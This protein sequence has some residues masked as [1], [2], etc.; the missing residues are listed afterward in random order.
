VT[1]LTALEAG[2]G[3][4]T[5]LGLPLVVS[6][7]TAVTS[8]MSGLTALVALTGGLG[9]GSLATILVV[10]LLLF[11]AVTGV[12]TVVLAAV[13]AATLGLLLGCTGRSSLGAVTG[14][15]IVLTAG[16]TRLL[17]SAS[18]LTLFAAGAVALE[19]AFFA[20]VVAGTGTRFL[21]GTIALLVGAVTGV[22]A[23]L[24]TGVASIGV[25]LLGG[26]GLLA[27]AVTGVMSLFTTVVAREG[28]LLDLSGFILALASDV[29]LLTTVE[30]FLLATATATAHSTATTT[31]LSGDDFGLSFSTEFF[32]V[33]GFTFFAHM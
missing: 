32:L 9:A 15:V 18:R 1:L 3:S 20:A 11:G 30:A 14:Q 21:F 27:G 4:T 26:G 12:V 33:G 31:S 16:V 24:T 5:G 17:L 10:G 22:M 2:T 19:M 6:T 23:F 29:A 28:F 13:V 7:L 8:V 25:L